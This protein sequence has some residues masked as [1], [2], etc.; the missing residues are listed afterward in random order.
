MSHRLQRGFVDVAHIVVLRVPS[1]EETA[2]AFV[3]I[4]DVDA[5]DAC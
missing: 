2:S 1:F 4:D 5:W 3:I